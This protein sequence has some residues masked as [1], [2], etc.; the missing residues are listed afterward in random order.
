MPSESSDHEHRSEPGEGL[1]AQ[2]N[3]WNF[4]L[5]RAQRPRRFEHIRFDSN[6]DCNLHCVYCHNPRSSDIIDM[7]DLR[8]F[9]EHNVI[10]AENFQIGC[11]MEPTLDKRLC[12]IMLLVGRSKAKPNNQ[13][14][15]QTNGI[16][17]FKHDHAKIRDSGLN[18]VTVSIDSANPATM[19]FLRG[20]V[21]LAKIARS[22][23]GFRKECPLIDVNIIAVVSK[24]NVAEI[25]SLVAFGLDHGVK[26]F[27]LREVF[28]YPDS[29]V[30]DH[31][32][33]PDLVLDEGD[34]AQMKEMVLARFGKRANFHFLDGPTL[35]RQSLKMKTD[36]FR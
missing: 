21:S 7:E 34:F 9:L 36:S 30:V 29:K 12:D 35:R 3:P 4:A 15:L 17:L 31:T 16:L 10:S 33:M 11:A 5:M 8:T 18:R 19:K 27:A 28:Y 14:R 13:F 1:D 22:V 20:G 26:M 25:E 23:A 24:A 6:N 32:K 2:L